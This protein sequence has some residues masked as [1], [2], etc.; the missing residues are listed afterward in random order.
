MTEPLVVALA[1]EPV[2]TGVTLW[3][4]GAQ[5]LRSRVRHGELAL[6]AGALPATARRRIRHG[7]VKE[8]LAGYGEDASRPDAFVTLGHGAVHAGVHQA[9]PAVDDDTDGPALVHALGVETG[10]NAF[11]VE[12]LGAADQALGLDAESALLARAAARRDARE[13]PGT[14]DAARVIVALEPVARAYG[15][16]GERIVASI[17]AEVRLD[18]RAAARRLIRR[19]EQGDAAAADRLASFSDALRTAALGTA[20]A[21]QDVLVVMLTGTLAAH[22]LLADEVARGLRVVAPARLLPGARLERA[23]ADAALDALLGR[24]TV[25]TYV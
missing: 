14:E 6:G 11:V 23:L 9:R 2:A 18:D 12:P 21:L 4:G 25:H 22:A 7:A 13:R 10:A 24:T 17:P 8:L 5:R 16:V 20:R 1:L 19:T 15:L 3:Q